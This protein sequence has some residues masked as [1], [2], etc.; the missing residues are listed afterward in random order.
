MIPIQKRRRRD[1]RLARKAQF[2]RPE[3][4][5]SLY[6][7]RTRGKRPRYI[8]S[9]EEDGG[10]DALSTR[11][12]NRQSGISTPAES[13]GPTFTASGRQV[14]SRH[15]GTYGETMLSGQQDTME[16]SKIGGSEGAEDDEDE[17][18][19][20]GRPRRAAQQNRLKAKL[21]SKKHNEGYDSLGSM[22]DESDATSSGN[23][24]DGGDEDE[25]DDHIDDEE[26][27]D[28][29]DM[30]DTS[31]AEDEEVTRQSLVVTLR[32]IKSRLSPP[33]QD[34]RS[35]PTSFGTE[36]IP[37]TLSEG[38]SEMPYSTHGLI[39]LLDDGPKAIQDAAHTQ[40]SR[41]TQQSPPL[42]HA[43]ITEHAAP[44]QYATLADPRA[45]VGQSGQN[46]PTAPE[47]D[48]TPLRPKHPPPDEHPTPTA[49]WPRPGT[50]VVAPNGTQ[51]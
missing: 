30:S 27:D 20:R 22:D 19:S 26:E 23:E 48:H 28:D 49:P 38:P 47:T 46:M 3:P 16:H 24:W 31:G 36:G 35:G 37:T 2:V 39:E 51:M 34:T 9:D 13:N 4:G 44:A 25:L 32:Y 41:P 21:L 11:R 18:V 5:F 42:H 50:G 12:S 10:S 43:V 7:G 6:E 33:R 8:Y 17:Q 14:R 40:Y 15:G 1:Y 45:Q 29:I